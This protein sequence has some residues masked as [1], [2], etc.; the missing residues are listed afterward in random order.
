MPDRITRSR[1]KGWRKPPGAVIVA[2][3]SIWG[4]LCPTMMRRVGKKA[5]GRLLD[6][7]EWNQM[8]GVAE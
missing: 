2:R 7:R 8:P 3:P 1:T 5:A 4:R 6:G